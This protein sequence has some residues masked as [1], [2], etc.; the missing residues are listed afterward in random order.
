MAC[1]YSICL[2]KWLDLFLIAVIF[3]EY[4]HTYQVIQQAFGI[5]NVM[6]RKE[7]HGKNRCELDCLC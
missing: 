4:V 2:E 7:I 6:T 3:A 5:D 1:Q